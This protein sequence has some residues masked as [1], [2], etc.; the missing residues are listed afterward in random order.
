MGRGLATLL[1]AI[2]TIVPAQAAV[3]ITFWSQE[4]GQSFPHAFFT[5]AGTPDAGGPA[6]SASYG[7]TAK[8]VTPALLA[9]SVPGMID[10]PKPGYIARSNAHFSVVLTDAQYTHVLAL[11]GEWGPAGDSHYNLN[12]RNC[13]HFVAEAGR[14]SGLTVTEPKRLMKKP[15]SFTRSMAQANVGRVTVIELPAKAYLA[16]M[17]QPPPPPVEAAPATVSGYPAPLPSTPR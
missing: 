15:R 2:G 12:R 5:L 13:V 8:A 17:T 7:F 9:G 4:L 3:T 16:T 6:V 1:L 11:V 14:R 10:R